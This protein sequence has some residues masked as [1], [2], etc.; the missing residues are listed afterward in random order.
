MI[1][2]PV[3][4]VVDLVERHLL[5]CS[6]FHPIVV[7]RLHWLLGVLFKIILVLIKH[8]VFVEVVVLGL[9]TCILAEGLL[10]VTHHVID[11]G[12]VVVGVVETDLSALLVDQCKL[13]SV[14][15]E[16]NRL[17]L[18]I[19]EQL[20]LSLVLGSIEVGICRRLWVGV[21]K[22]VINIIHFC[23]NLVI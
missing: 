6:V 17:R 18:R 10:I 14:V 5:K 16:G 21:Q 13:A 23:C 11:S 15:A 9:V 19:L 12:G 1:V 8:H 22:V 7:H 3:L 2:L 4:H 20:P